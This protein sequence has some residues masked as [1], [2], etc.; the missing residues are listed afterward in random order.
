MS[1]TTIKEVC[2]SDARALRSFVALERRWIGSN[3]L[4]VS[5][6]DADVIR[7]LSGRSEFFSE[8]EHALFVAS[9][10]GREIARCAA[11]INRK[12]QKAKNERAGFIGYFAAEPGEETGVRALFER[13]EAWLRDRGVDRIIAPFNGA[14]ILGAGARS[15]AY[16]E[17]P[18]FPFGWQPPYYKE[19]LVAVGYKPAYPLWYY[20]VSFDSEKYRDAKRR[21][22]ENHKVRVRPVNKKLWNQDL[23]TLRVLFNESFRDEWEFHPMTSG[24]FHEFFDPMKPVRDPRQMLIGEV[25]GEPAGFCL[26]MPDWNPLFRSFKGKLGLVPIVRLMLGARR[27]RRAGLLGLG[28]LPAYRGTGLARSLAVALYSRYEELGLKEAFYYPVNEDNARSRSFAESMGGAGRVL[29]HCYDKRLKHS[30]HSKDTTSSG[31][32][33]R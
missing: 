17:E 29:A 14:A 12:Y 33:L 23:E 22:G 31:P 30:D 32:A 10:A 7:G 6:I 5:E 20:T 28:A 21:A 1:E 2:P 26:G 3:P 4:F 19:Y 25:D 15:A 16:D 8:M 13:S 11:L 24:E 9:S 18:M 27:Y